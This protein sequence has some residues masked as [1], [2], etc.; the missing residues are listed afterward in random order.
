CSF[1]VT[2][3]AQSGLSA[4]AETAGTSARTR[5]Q[6]ALFMRA[7]PETWCRRCR[8]ARAYW[9]ANRRTSSRNEH[10]LCSVDHFIGQEQQLAADA[11][12]KRLGGLEIDD[13]LELGRLHYGKV[14]GLFAL[15][16]TTDVNTELPGSFLPMGSIAHQSASLDGF[17]IDVAGGDPMA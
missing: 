17:S 5:T 1:S 15:E 14:G 6:T 13:H 3:N 4:A 10:A 16:H 12:T 2:G 9:P 8:P 7:P 11:E